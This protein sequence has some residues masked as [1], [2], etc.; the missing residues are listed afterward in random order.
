MYVCARALLCVQSRE[1]TTLLKLDNVGMC[2][3]ARVF[4]YEGPNNHPGGTFYTQVESVPF[5][6]SCYF[7]EMKMDLAF[8]SEFLFSN[9]MELYRD[10][11]F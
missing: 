1:I 3:R 8:S 11:L 4:G 6:L 2:L 9:N 10:D 5:R 7:L